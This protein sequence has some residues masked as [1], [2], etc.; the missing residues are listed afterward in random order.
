MKSARFR[1]RHELMKKKYPDKPNA[2]GVP[3][4]GLT[5]AILDQVKRNISNMPFDMTEYIEFEIPWATSDGDWG[6]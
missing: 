1:I 6:Q 3:Y 4:T 5:K 2:K